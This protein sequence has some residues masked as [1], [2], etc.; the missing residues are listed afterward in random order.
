MQQAWPFQWLDN[1]KAKSEHIKQYLI[2]ENMNLSSRFLNDYAFSQVLSRQADKG[3]IRK[4]VLNHNNDISA[5]PANIGMLHDLVILDL[6]DNY[7]RDIPWSIVYL[8]NL[9]MLDLSYNMLSTLPRVVGYLPNLVTLD[10]S[11]NH[12]TYLPTE[13]L[14]LAKLQMLNVD[15]NYRLVSP[16]LKICEKGKAAIFA[17]LAK[18][19]AR[20]NLWEES[21]AYASDVMTSRAGVKS[22][23]EQCIVVIFK[24]DVDYLQPGYVPPVVKDHLTL[25]SVEF[26][27]NLEVAKCSV[28]KK[29][30]SNR[31]LFENH[32]CK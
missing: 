31:Y 25:K 6:R 15:R 11:A 19:T 4:L 24:C 1:L 28:C 9:Q 32:H 22:L 7:I 26:N 12:L 30:Y 29:F 17:A 27:M 14:N 21:S 8:K 23:L 10:V 2:A 20:A 5:V 16:P 13:L 18:R 3:N